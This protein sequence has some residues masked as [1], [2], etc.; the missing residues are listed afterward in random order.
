[1]CI[2]PLT[3]FGF[4]VKV[5]RYNNPNH[6]IVAPLFP[7]QAVAQLPDGAQASLELIQPKSDYDIIWFKSGNDFFLYRT[8]TKEWK[9]L[10]SQIDEIKT[11][12]IYIFLGNDDSVWGMQPGIVDDSIP[13][14]S[15]YNEVM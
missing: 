4:P 2:P 13:L 11:A 10:S 14:L 7:W 15:R 12:P 6:Q 8:D 3:T 5:E 9:T 1:K